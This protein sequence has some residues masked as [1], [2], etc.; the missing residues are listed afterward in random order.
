VLD[1]YDDWA[2]LSEVQESGCVLVRPD[3]FVAW[4]AAERAADCDA[5]L[6]DVLA[7]LLGRSEAGAG[8][9][10]SGRELAET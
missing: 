1:T 5:V 7:Q 9:A 4:R 6:G 8:A 10:D 2:R 3:G